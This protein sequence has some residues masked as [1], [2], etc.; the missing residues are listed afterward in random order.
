MHCDFWRGGGSVIGTR[1]PTIEANDGAERRLSLTPAK[2]DRELAQRFVFGDADAVREVYARFSGAVLTVAM[3]RLEDRGLAEEAVQE[4]FVKAWQKA[5]TFDPTRELSPWLYQ[6]ARRTAAD[7]QRREQRRPVNTTSGLVEPIVDED[8][9]FVDAWERWEVRRALDE[10][11]RAER[12]LLR[13]AH[14]ARLSQSEMAQRFGV[15]V[16]TVKSRLH[17]AHRRLA[18]RLIHLEPTS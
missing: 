15:P 8:V 6:I 1:D 17:R 5:A 11:P 2:S 10:L 3:S 18:A 13:L 7:I 14:Y 9:T 4:T 16:G 12:E